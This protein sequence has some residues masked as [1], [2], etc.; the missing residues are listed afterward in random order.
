MQ[1]ADVIAMPRRAA[2]SLLTEIA[3]IPGVAA[4]EGRIVKL[5]LLDIPEFAEPATGEFISLPEGGQPRLNQLYLRSGRLPQPASEQEVVGTDGFAK[6]HN[7]VPG[8][9]FSAIL[10]GRKRA[11]VIVVTSSSPQL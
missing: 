7:F 10:N 4:A 11:L 5:A 9:Q 3:E 6:A 8:S 2:K 1:F